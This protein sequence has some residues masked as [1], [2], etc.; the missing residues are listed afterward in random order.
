MGSK[1]PSQDEPSIGPPPPYNVESVV[2]SSRVSLADENSHKDLDIDLE[3]GKATNIKEP[4]DEAARKGCCVPCC[5]WMFFTAIVVAA[6]AVI[7]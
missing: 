4:G 6:A 2:P 1:I 3:D 7:V 5:G